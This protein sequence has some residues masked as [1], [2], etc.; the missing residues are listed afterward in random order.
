MTNWTIQEF[1]NII[2]GNEDTNAVVDDGDGPGFIGG[3]EKGWDYIGGNV[4]PG[5]TVCVLAA[6]GRTIEQ[7]DP[8]E[9]ASLKRQH[10]WMFA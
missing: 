5:D 1:T 10:P 6:D 2:G 7:L 8:K 4:S 3:Y 9:L